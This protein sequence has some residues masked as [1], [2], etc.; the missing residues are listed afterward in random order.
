LVITI[1][2]GGDNPVNGGLTHGADS[3]TVHLAKG[4]RAR[5]LDNDW[6]MTH[7]MF[8]LAFPT[9]PPRYLWMMEG[10]SDYLEPL[11]RGRVGQLTPLQVWLEYAQGLP[12]GLPEE[13]DRGLDN[14]P[15]RG[16]IYW[17]GNL[18][19]LLADVKIRQ[20]SGNRHSVDD[21]IRAILDAGGDGGAEWSLDKVL[22]M[23]RK[24]TGT[25]VLKDLHDELGPKPGEVDLP[26]LWKQLGVV[27]RRR[28]VTF[29]DTAPLA[30]IRSA[31]TA[32]NGT[33]PMTVPGGNRR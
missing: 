22:E 32:T 19:W 18:F 17:G 29:D 31:I 24:A 28:R 30:A 10:L 11:A 2:P 6:I 8:H 9:L 27:Y 3:I 1:K 7:E 15:T 23:G 20:Q 16:R 26:A 14:T 21:V 4:A 5:D 13:G 33:G 12:E 25:T